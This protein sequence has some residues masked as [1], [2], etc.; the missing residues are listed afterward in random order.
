[1]F[2]TTPDPDHVTVDSLMI[3]T[4]DAT[5]WP[6]EGEPMSMRLLLPG[7]PWMATALAELLLDW[8]KE[9]AVVSL[10]LVRSGDR[11]TARMTHHRATV[12]LALEAA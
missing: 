8:A 12:S 4:D 7:A 2:V 11:L 1:M 6:S 10:A 3:D 5:E 9:D